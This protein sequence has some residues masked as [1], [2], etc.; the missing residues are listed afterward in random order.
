[1]L[2]FDVANLFLQRVDKTS[3]KLILKS[4]GAQ[5][6]RDCDIETG[7]IFHNCNDYSNLAVGERCHIGKSCFFDLRNKI[8]IQNNT[9]ISMQCSFITHIDMSKS[10][11]HKA[12]P[13]RSE[14]IVVHQNVYI[15]ARAT[16]LMGTEIKENSILAAGSL[17]NACLDS[18]SLY[19]GIPAKRVR[20]I[21]A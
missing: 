11:L 20:Y 17:A 18:N 5:I 16:I 14:A 7:L 21:R 2:G 9:V 15:G 4:N 8:I 13:S 12:Y 6:G 19:A 1:L 10:I 3:L